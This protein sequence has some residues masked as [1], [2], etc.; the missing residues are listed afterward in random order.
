MTA[1]LLGVCTLVAWVADLQSCKVPCRAE[2]Q[3]NTPCHSYAFVAVWK[4]N[5]DAKTCKAGY[6]FSY[7]AMA[8]CL[9]FS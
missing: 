6:I 5:L 8:F 7:C 1:D 9:C 2:A 3:V 4:N